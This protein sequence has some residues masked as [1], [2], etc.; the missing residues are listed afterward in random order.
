MRLN[1]VYYSLVAAISLTCWFGTQ[2]AMAFVTVTVQPAHQ[3]VFAGS[4]AVVSAYAT[5]TAGETIT[6]YEWRMSTNGL[7]PFT[8][9]PGATTATCILTNVQSRDAGQYFVKVSFDSGASN[10]GIAISGAVTLAVVDPAR[11]MAQPQLLNRLVGASALFSVGA[12]GLSAPGYQWRLNGANLV[13]SD[14]VTGANAARLTLNSLVVA[15]SGTYDVVVAS[16]YSAVTSAGATLGVYSPVGSRVP[17]QNTTVIVGSNAVFSVVPSGSGPVSFRWQRDGTNL[18][19]GGRIIGST[20]NVLTILATTTNDAGRY[21]VS[22]SNPASTTTSAAA[23]LTV[24]EA[25]RI[26][27]GMSAAGQ[28]G[29]YFNFTITA[30]GKAPIMFNANGLPGGLSLNPATGV[31]SGWPLVS[32]TFPITL[33][34]ANLEGS[35]SRVL[36]L[37]ISSLAPVITSATTTNWTEENPTNFTYTIKASNNPTQFGASNLPLGL[38]LD[39]TTGVI[40]GTPLYGGIFTIPI[41]AINAWGTGSANL[42]LTN[43]YAPITSL[44]IA[45]VTTN[46]SKPYLLDFSFS[47]R[48]G[49]KPVVRPPGEFK[50]VCMED[51]VPTST[52]EAPPILASVMGSG[53]KQRKTILA[54]DYTYS[55]FAVPGAF[56]A[57]QAAAQLLINEEPPH[58]LFGIIEFNADY[59][60]PQFVTNGLTSAGNY[61]MSDKTAL[62]QSIA[63][64]QDNYVQGNYAGS[65]CWD[66]LHAALNQFGANNPDEQRYV[67]A[68]T[69][70]NDDASLLH[71]NA[72]NTL[73]GLARTNHVALYCVA[74]GNKV[75]TNTLKQLTSQTGGQYYLAAT[76]T[77]LALQFERIEKD[78]SCQ[79]VL[80]W[81]TFQRAAV[82]AYPAPGF[83]PS[84]R[85]TCEGLTASWNT[86]LG[87]VLYT[88]IVLTNDMSITNTYLTNAVKYPFNPPDWAGDVRAGSLRLL[89]DADVGPQRILLRASYVPR[90]VREIR[91]NYRPNYPCT[92]SL[93]VTGTNDVL[94]GWSLSE[95]TDTNGLRTLTLT[96]PDPTDLRTSI[97]Y[98]AFGNLV[99]FNFARPES[100]TAAQAFSVFS[101]DNSIYTDMLP[102]G[103]SFVM[104]NT[105]Q[106]ITVYE[107]TP[108]GTPVPWLLANGF[109]NN[110]AAAELSDPDGDGVP[111]WQEY[112][113][114]TNPRDK[115]SAFTVRPVSAPTAGQPFQM[116]ISTVVG[117]TYRVETATSLGS[118]STLQD[119]IAGTGGLVTV[120]DTRN[121]LGVTVVFY[122]VSVD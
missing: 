1:S 62:S 114:G 9:I 106:F 82:P 87:S 57:M 17:P 66:A 69:D 70:G 95:T 101:V 29:A 50:V 30:T 98:A 103:Q 41:W 46:W 47:L 2:E 115:N 88:N 15:D 56:D 22:V 35:D 48:N 12:E 86:S 81:A 7:N 28:Q 72:V 24:L 44:A 111:T 110:F 37:T 96:S 83:Q 71:T 112:W 38:S 27:S 89:A 10:G 113:A 4:N 52:D 90:F 59:M 97:E 80:R 36:T 84:F 53:T 13:D 108:Y 8:R 94:Y 49:T 31:I 102:S 121:L 21:T 116:R 20:S 58:A 64:I 91:I 63:G 3:D 78:I 43:G 117:R 118:W 109:T 18:V 26:T 79:Y 40:S 99:S 105:N 67:V 85:L 14:R 119:G 39:A 77:D 93:E 25:A 76:T 100:M 68:M 73:I 60:D 104:E 42:V 32:G 61:F 122:R 55:M 45:N 19:D 33:G 34:A 16:G 5:A 23:T 74:F 75:N 92:A 65:R 51:G 54:L 107:L 11:I 120:T 6:G